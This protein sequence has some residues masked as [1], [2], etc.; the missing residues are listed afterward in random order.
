MSVHHRSSNLELLRT[1]AELLASNVLRA[2]VHAGS[3]SQKSGQPRVGAL[4]KDRSD[5]SEI[6]RSEISSFRVF[7]MGDLLVAGVGRIA[8]KQ[9]IISS[10]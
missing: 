10:R 9:A 1:S 3:C 5:S 4:Q 2:G 7:A 6:F 8:Y